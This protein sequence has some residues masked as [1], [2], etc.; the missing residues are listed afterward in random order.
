MDRNNELQK[1]KLSTSNDK[2]LDLKHEIMEVKVKDLANK[3][4]EM[5]NQVA[6]D[7]EKRAENHNHKKQYVGKQLP[8][9]NPG[10]STPPRPSRVIPPM[11]SE[12]TMRHSIADNLMEILVNMSNPQ[13]RQ[14][15]FSLL[16]VGDALQAR[17]RILGILQQI[18]ERRRTRT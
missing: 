13:H 7:L 16:Q 15:C 3:D 14:Q 6:K 18:D 11:P 2:Y 8:S 4:I 1:K 10:Q 17:S 12:E 5:E 9:R